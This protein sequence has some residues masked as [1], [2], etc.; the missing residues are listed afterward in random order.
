MELDLTVSSS[1]M[2]ALFFF[3][4]TILLF[5]VFLWK[6]EHHAGVVFPTLRDLIDAVQELVLS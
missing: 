5:L 3:L 2:H 1:L 4:F 6:V